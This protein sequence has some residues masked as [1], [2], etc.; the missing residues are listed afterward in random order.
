MR[1]VH[2]LTCT[3]LGLQTDLLHTHEK[4]G[5]VGWGVELEEREG[6]GRVGGEG[7]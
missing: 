3:C 7:V 4:K 2:L 5:G 6:K 1:S